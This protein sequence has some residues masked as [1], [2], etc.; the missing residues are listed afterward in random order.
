MEK[1][2]IALDPG[3]F[4]PTRAHDFDGGLD[5][6]AMNDV[7]L[8]PQGSEFFDTGVHIAVPRGYVGLVKSRSGLMRK[9]SIDTDGTIDADYTGSIGITLINHSGADVY[10]KRGD[11]IAQ[12]VIV[13][14]L[15]PRTEDFELVD[16]LEETERGNGG[17]GSTGR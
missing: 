13:P 16:E 4:M 8:R 14:C 6:Y 17:F 5:F 1:I 12:L 15:L 10:I 7:W 11:R 2:K 3:A 9:N